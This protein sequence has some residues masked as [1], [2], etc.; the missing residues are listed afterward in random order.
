M[1]GQAYDD[2][3]VG[4]TLVVNPGD[5]IELT[6]DNQL[7]VHT[8]LH[9]HGMHVSP[10]NNGD[11]IFLSIDPGE[12]FA[13]SLAI[14]DNH[15]S[16]TFWYHS[17]AHTLSEEQVFAGLSGMII[18]EG[19]TDLLPAELQEITDIAVGLKDAQVVGD[20][21]E[22]ENID[23][24]ASDPAGRELGIDAGPGDRPGRGAAL[25]SGEHRGGHLVRRR[26]GGPAADRHWRGRQPGVG[27]L[28]R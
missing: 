24:N 10:A 9:F 11:N 23:S 25:A 19:L 16:G 3:L 6:L 2:G 14:P 18:V 17:H 28:E 22:T 15:P 12:Q 27:S 8:N 13:Y 20:S 21:I 4:P 5:T 26:A 7:D 1:Q